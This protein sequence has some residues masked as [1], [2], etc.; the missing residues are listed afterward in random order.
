MTQNKKAESKHFSAFLS[1]SGKYDVTPGPSAPCCV[2]R[3]PLK[4]GLRFSIKA[5]VPS[6]ASYET[7]LRIEKPSSHWK[8]TAAPIAPFLHHANLLTFIAQRQR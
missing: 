8:G 1:F 5:V 6:W 7:D 3:D 2:F 4:V